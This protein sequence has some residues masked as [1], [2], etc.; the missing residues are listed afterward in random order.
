[1]K[2]QTKLI[3]SLGCRRRPPVLL[4]ACDKYVFVIDL[5]I[6]GAPCCQ[7]SCCASPSRNKFCTRIG[8]ARYSK[9]TPLSATCNHNGIQCALHEPLKRLPT[10]S[11]ESAVCRLEPN[12]ALTACSSKWLHLE[13][14]Q[15][16]NCQRSAFTNNW[17]SCFLV[18]QSQSA[19][20]CSDILTGVVST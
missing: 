19:L 4:I 14:L 16:S 8:F 11:I 6:R 18:P 12:K 10:V 2:S 17:R 20:T 5:R 13:R 7:V 3:P 15:I 1:M 9:D